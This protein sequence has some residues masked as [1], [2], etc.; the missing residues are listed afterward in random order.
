MRAT[1]MCEKPWIQVPMS[2]PGLK[3]TDDNLRQQPNRFGWLDMGRDMRKQL[4]SC[5]SE[6]LPREVLL[7]KT[8]VYGVEVLLGVEQYR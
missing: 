1:Q 8:V 6:A 2:T 3:R 7:S 4:E 5:N